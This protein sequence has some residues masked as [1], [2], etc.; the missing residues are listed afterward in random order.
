MMKKQL[1]KETKALL[2]C[3]VKF[4]ILLFTK[5]GQAVLKPIVEIAPNNDIQVEYNQ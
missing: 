4:V 1:N 2:E 3:S 5:D